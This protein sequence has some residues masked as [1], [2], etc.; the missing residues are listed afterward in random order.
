[1]KICSTTFRIFCGALLLTMFQILI[2]SIQSFGQTPPANCIPTFTTACT[3]LM[4]PNGYRIGRVEMLPGI[5]HNIEN[6]TSA[7]LTS[8]HTDMVQ[9][10][11]PGIAQNIYITSCAWS[12]VSVY[13]DF[14][15]DGYFDDIYEYI[16]NG[17]GGGANGIF[18]GQDVSF[19]VPLGTPMG[20]H[21]LRIL[22][23]WG[24]TMGADGACYAYNGLGGGN[25]FDFTINVTCAS[26]ASVSISPVDPC[27]NS[28]AILTANL[29]ESVS[30]ATAATV[31]TYKWYDAA[32]GGNLLYTGQTFTTLAL[33]TAT[34]FYVT[35]TNN[36]GAPCASSP[37]TPVIVGIKPPLPLPT[38]SPTTADICLPD[39]VLLTA[40]PVPVLD[41]AIMET[42]NGSLPQAPVLCAG[43]TTST[44]EILYTAAEL[45]APP[46][47]PI[48]I[49]DLNFDKVG[50]NATFQPGTVT[51]YLKNTPATTLTNTADLTGYTQV[52][53]GPIPYGTPGWKQI[54]LDDL[55]LYNSSENLAVLIVRNG[56]SGGLTS[57][58]T[59]KAT[60][61]T[62]Q[63]SYSTAQITTTLPMTLA[64]SKPNAIIGYTYDL[65]VNWSP[66]AGLFEDAALTTALSAGDTNTLVYTLTPGT[67]AARSVWEDCVSEPAQVTVNL[68][69][70]S[71]P[72]LEPILPFCQ[73]DAVTALP[74]MSTNG[75]TGTW[76]PAVIDNNTPGAGTFIFTPDPGQCADT[77]SLIVLVNPTYQATEAA[78]ICAGN[79]YQL[80]T[81]I[82][83]TTGNYEEVFTTINGCDSSI[84]LE[85]TVTPYPT[86]TNVQ[87]L[88]QG[89][90]YVF[91]GATYTADNNTATDTF[92]T[93]AGCDSIV[94][95]DL[96]FTPAITHIENVS[97]CQGQFYSFD[98][99]D[100]TSSVA[101]VI[102]NFSTAAGCDSIVTLNLTVN[103]Y[104]TG[105]D[106]H[107]LC[108]GQS[109]AFNGTTYTADNNTATDTLQTAAGC[110]SIVTL[111]LSFTP[112]ITH[113]N[114]ASICQ[115]QSYSFDGT[116]YT[117]SVSGITG[118]FSTDA[119]CDSIVTLN[120]TVSPYLT[121]TDVQVICQ[122]QGYTFNGSTYT[123]DNNTATDTLQ[124]ADG[125]D[126]IVT[127]NLTVN[128]ELLLEF[129]Q[130]APFC[131]DV[132]TVPVLP[133]TD[134]N[135][136]SGSWSPAIISA[137]LGTTSYTFTP[138]AGQGCYFNY[139]M[140]ITVN[141]CSCQNPATVDAGESQVICASG[142]AT[143]SGN[144]TVA[145]TATWTT[146][147]SG[148]FADATSLNTSYTASEADIAAGMVT[149][150]LTT[151]D[152]DGPVMGCV[153]VADDIVLTIDPVLNV[154]I[155][156]PVNLCMDAGNS[157][158]TSNTPGGVW[159]S[160]NTGVALIDGN[161]QLS[162]VAP[163]V[164]EVSYTVTNTCGIDAASLEV[165]VSEMTPLPVITG[166]T[167]ICEGVVN[168]TLTADLPGG[169]WSS[170]D[171]A[172]ATVDATGLVTVM[173]AGT[174]TI[175][176]TY[177]NNS[178][179]VMQVATHSI[180]VSPGT[181]DP[182]ITGGA[183]VCTGTVLPLSATPAGGIWSSDNANAIVDALGVVT[184]V[185]PGNATI[186]YT[187]TDGC[188]ATSNAHAITI[189][190]ATPVPQILGGNELCV[191]GS[192][193][194]ES[195]LTGGNWT[196]SNAVVATIDM[197]TG[198]VSPLAAGTTLINYTYTDVCGTQ[199][200]T[201]NL[202]IHPAYQNAVTAEICQ[203]DAYSFGS[204]LLTASGTYTE[205]F[206]TVN[207]CDSIVT[208]DLAVHPSYSVISTATICTGESYVLGGQSLTASG[209]YTELFTAQNGCDSI[210][211]LNL[212]VSPTPAILQIDTAAC[213]QVVF[214]GQ[215]YTQN[216]T[217][218][219]V[220][221]SS[222][223]C[224]SVYRTV[225]VTVWG[226]PVSTISI[227]ANGCDQL[228]FEGQTYTQNTQFVDTLQDQAGCDSVIRN[229]V[230][231]I[232]P[233]Y[234]DTL[235]VDICQGE[236]YLFN[237]V[238]YSQSGFY[239]DQFTAFNGCDS[240]SSLYLTMQP[241]PV[242]EIIPEPQ[243]GGY[244]IG[245]EVKLLA[246]GAMQYSW[247]ISYGKDLGTG[248]E[249]AVHLPLPVQEVWVKG[250]T[251]NSCMDSTAI[252]I[253]AEACCYV[254]MP[255]AFSPN[256][257][258]LN[259]GFGPET[260]G[261]PYEF[262]M[263]IYNRAGHRIFIGYKKEDKWDGTINGVP[264]DVGGYYYQVSGV[265]VDGSI[266]H[267]KGDF[268]L[269]R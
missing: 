222:M 55:F 79:N 27:Y 80:G 269:I 42:G 241:L 38:V 167:Q 232:Y 66:V 255:N 35:A 32:V 83:T 198:V 217:I 204:Q 116:D 146:S 46:G 93:T 85:L 147:G 164:T 19:T 265:C 18:N 44:A 197:T 56:N 139:T 191:T 98:G 234:A 94:T 259:D 186:A 69:P 160:G 105:T 175:S 25:F 87:V 50:G 74:L 212:N 127:L 183:D 251:E 107:V 120:L 101:A 81:Q 108:Q 135:D 206:A 11:V 153:P 112:A 254:F 180:A 261:N 137:V 68:Q 189:N 14:N 236:N 71:D 144:I 33:T 102:G 106:V 155:D 64:P 140:D 215:I 214:E 253:N 125:C 119:G 238:S 158:F 123:T 195:N 171:N 75:I 7:C 9:D 67:Y 65:P 248:A 252:T 28:S 121:G 151:A 63:C 211:T 213:N 40:T 103:P 262:S 95:L 143:L 209:S 39:A 192:L 178:G 43:T 30:P 26:I 124:T 176:Y 227:D 224:D 219:D 187:Y 194:L 45:N 24:G 15:D 182:V 162:L 196:S 1:M 216:N 17:G 250:T 243:P 61:A 264:A 86:G 72:V 133:P 142:I 114:N 117:S 57:S 174:V 73:G 229:I 201:Q 156:G 3:N 12:Q 53:T 90:S 100:Y 159:S 207:V 34:T 267:Q 29:I 22:A 89:Q 21:R 256:G 118:N 239:T 77:G 51:I 226:G 244:C 168:P 132:A 60:T 113:T 203:G 23:N 258:G 181:P 200:S 88:C 218:N 221:L 208:L 173:A 161:G 260:N 165:T 8:D 37:R 263:Y 52:Y 54:I 2:T 41:S 257:D 97:V 245:D 138:D 16:G 92:Q 220:L 6:N 131:S 205:V 76:S 242:L 240:I 141:D 82:L 157:M 223:G 5:N 78:T 150:T 145:P 237:E 49:T 230:I 110:D 109:Y 31:N 99:T 188:G 266:I 225:N 247:W 249:V 172:V 148:S 70:G 184:G 96:S 130:I 210:V 233:S 235:F 149:L 129:T 115:G 190:P 163:G 228:E 36:M 91:N 111:D 136:V 231:Q 59:Y 202:T 62:D 199:I 10:V 13:C 193:D 154:T 48:R 58:P 169:I 185:T 4:Q 179:C 166:P 84:I 104:L 268:T 20:F 152:P 47:I 246:T 122:G 177:T 128:P 170:S 126:S 134:M